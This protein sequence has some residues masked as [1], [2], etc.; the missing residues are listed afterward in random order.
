MATMR[1]RFQRIELSWIAL[2]LSGMLVGAIL[3]VGI[4]HISQAK[5]QVG[6]PVAVAP[7]A[8]V[9]E[10]V[11]GRLGGIA[12][13][14]TAND[15]FVRQGLAHAAIVQ[16]PE[17]LIIDGRLG[18]IESADTANDWLVRQGLSQTMV[19]G[20]RLGGLSQSDTP[21][22]LGAGSSTR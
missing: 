20:G 5:P 22:V 6:A 12:S 11:G 1:M 9:S 4:T 19:V 14:D 10:T 15:D 13:T 21:T 7:Q 8:Q 3:V 17:P 2:V 18:G 16:A